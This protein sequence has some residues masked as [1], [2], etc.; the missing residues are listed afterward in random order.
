MLN[1]RYHELRNIK[2]G[3]KPK[4]FSK[5]WRDLIVDMSFAQ[6]WGSRVMIYWSFPIPIL[7]PVSSKLYIPS[8]RI[9][10][11]LIVFWSLWNHPS[12][13]SGSYDCF[14][15]ISIALARHILN[16]LY[17]SKNQF[18]HLSPNLGAEGSDSYKID[19]AA[20]NSISR[21]GNISTCST[22]SMFRQRA[23]SWSF[24][25]P[26][27]VGS[28]VVRE[29]L[30]WTK[31]RSRNIEYSRQASLICSPSHD[32][33]PADDLRLEARLWLVPTSWIQKLKLCQTE[34]GHT[35]WKDK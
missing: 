8:V 32:N 7:K 19:W 31:P 5:K 20:F 21:R 29:S 24:D 15:S 9:P 6:F 27:F 26:I 30:P 13:I 35:E 25:N 34:Y 11:L 17:R 1:D 23:I 4:D 12:I 3:I 33:Y 10:Y 18:I 16:S 28:R 22:V 14:P 2:R